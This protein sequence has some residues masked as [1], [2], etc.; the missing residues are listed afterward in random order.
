VDVRRLYLLWLAD[1]A[2]LHLMAEHFE[3]TD[4]IGYLGIAR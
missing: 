1:R 4:P 3:G 2:C